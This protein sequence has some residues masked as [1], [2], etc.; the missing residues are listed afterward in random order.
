MIDEQVIQVEVGA[1]KLAGQ[2]ILG[3][4]KLIYRGMTGTKFGKQSLQ[5][6]NRQGRQLSTEEIDT[7]QLQDIRHRLRQYSVDF[8]YGKDKS[9]GKLMLFFKAQDAD[10]VGAAL[11]N[12]IADLG[13][14]PKKGLQTSIHDIC[15]A[16][17]EKAAA[18]NAL[19]P[20]KAIVPERGERT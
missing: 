16:A 17:K 13:K 15:A 20:A 11:Q 2:S 19:H 8:S 4:L 3:L 12:V 18:L 14:E 5:Q 9:T 1:A 6:L 10:R 7:G